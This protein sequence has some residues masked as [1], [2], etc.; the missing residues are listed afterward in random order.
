MKT[1]KVKNQ[2]ERDGFTKDCQNIIDDIDHNFEI[3]SPGFKNAQ[4]LFYISKEYKAKGRPSQNQTQT[5][6][7]S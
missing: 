1:I 2:Q 3:H 4:K 6:Q 7:K 5:T